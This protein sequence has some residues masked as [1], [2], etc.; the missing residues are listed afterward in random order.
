MASRKAAGQLAIERIVNDFKVNLD[1]DLQIHVSQSEMHRPSC[2]FLHP[3]YGIVAI[4]LGSWGEN[5]TEIRKR[6][7]GKVEQLRSQL[8]DS[9]DITIQNVAIVDDSKTPF[10][11]ISSTSFIAGAD[12]V[13]V[14]DWKSCLKPVS[15]TSAARD[16]LQRRLWPSMSFRVDTYRGT[17]DEGKVERD[18]SRAILDAEQSKIALS[19]SDEVMVISGP[20]GSG[21]TLVLV[22]RARYL[23]A[24]NP[25][26]K[27]VVVVYNKMLA[28]H[29]KNLVDEW[30][31]NIKVVT[32][33]KFLEERGEKQ[34]ARLSSDYQ[35]LDAALV[36][37]RRIVKDLGVKGI[38]K[39][40]D[41]MLVDEWQDFST[42]YISYL[43]NT[44]RKKKGGIVFAGDEKQSIYTDGLPSD[45]L[46]NIEVKKVKLKVPYRS[47]RQ[48]LDVAQ[49]LDSSFEFAGS[50]LAAS[51]E[52]VSLIFAE[53]WQLQAEAIAWEID[54]LIE[55]G[56]HALGEIV[57]LCT[58]KSGARY[59][60]AAL[61]QRRIPNQL[62]TNFWEDKDP[63][64][65]MVN[66]MTVHGGKGF[67]FKVV[68]VLGFET[69]RDLDGSVVRN[70]WGR[71][72]FVAVTRA[73]DLLFILYKTQTQFMTNL[74][75]CKK[76][77]LVAR[78]YPDD[79]ER[80]W[81]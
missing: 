25:D 49:A 36:S 39:D 77:T 40:I 29:V 63:A 31:K 8:G 6:L 14:V 17:L 62:L 74:K 23:A 45:A 54:E 78:S 11:K 75:K 27:I 18:A 55:T 34:L 61:S 10:E 71:V 7:N 4:E 20:P 64:D 1:C 46:K 22:A 72:G 35:D 26:W 37:A 57:V 51:G 59:V 41:A 70:K 19:A 44:I 42:P 15:L 80:K 47:T 16:K 33:K 56:Q 60:E 38:T 43:L 69:L 67:G 58:T 12:S 5:S 30:P 21:K 68:F 24:L 76:D 28:K 2:L 32:L 73:E 9:S 48:I 52:P 13:S 66:I 65:D 79:Y 3:N 81:K 53:T 50:D